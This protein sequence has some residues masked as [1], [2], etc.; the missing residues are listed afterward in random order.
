MKNYILYISIL[1]VFSQI[2][3]TQNTVSM[4]GIDQVTLSRL[5]NPAINDTTTN[6]TFSFPIISYISVEA[7]I[8]EK[9]IFTL[10][11]PGK[12]INNDISDRINKI[13]NHKILGFNQNMQIFSLSFRKNK[14]WYEIGMMQ[15]INANI[16]IPKNYFKLFWEGNATSLN[17]EMDLSGLNINFNSYYTYYFSVSKFLPKIGL[18]LG[19]RAKLYN[20]ILAVKSEMHDASFITVESNEHVYENY[21]NANM[22]TFTS[23]FDIDNIEDIDIANLLFKKSLEFEN[24]GY[25]FDLGAI[26]DINNSFRASASVTDLFAH[27]N[28]EIDV[29]EYD[30]SLDYV[31]KGF[32]ADDLGDTNLEDELDKISDAVE[33]DSVGK[34][35]F[36]LRVPTNIYLDLR[37]KLSATHSFGMLWKGEDNIDFN[38]YYSMYYLYNFDEIFQ[39]KINYTVHQ[40]V[41]ND[42][43]MTLVSK[44]GPVQFYLSGNNLSGFWNPYII[45]EMGFVFGINFIW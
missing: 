40:E 30:S 36:S 31:F 33:S 17:Q 28:Y 20:G 32:D 27:I 23:G 35:P 14:S 44:S 29:A 1:L 21:I 6:I 24:M 16:V 3:F 25:G 34:H 26:W 11:E 4:Y 15:S 45:S 22:K 8:N 39:F 9:N 43:S 13:D 38:N 12:N 42:I 2:G 18:N 19:V 41:Y 5:T 7:S 37:Y 10:F